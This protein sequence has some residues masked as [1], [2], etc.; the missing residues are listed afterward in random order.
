MYQEVEVV[1]QIA[2]G[3]LETGK[4]LIR[5]VIYK[6]QELLDRVQDFNAPYLEGT[7]HPSQQQNCVTI[8]H[9]YRVEIFYAVID[10]QLMKLNTIFNEKTRELLVLSS[11]LN[12]R[13]DFQ[14]FDIDNLCSLA[15]KYYPHDV[16]D[17]DDLRTKLEHFEYQLSELEEFQNL[18]TL[19]VLCQEFVRTRTPFVLIE[20]LVRLVMTLPVSTATIERAFSAMKIIKN[21]LRSKM[22]YGFLADLM[23]V[24]IEKD[25]VDTNDSDT[26]INEFYGLVLLVVKTGVS[27]LNLVLDG[28]TLDVDGARA[29]LNGEIGVERLSRSV[30]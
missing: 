22:S 17:L 25:I 13:F 30:W 10:F 27:G 18:C 6:E 26:V 2:A 8:E 3:E 5:H 23:T 15:E 11:S 9:Y 19:S 21:Q 7:G 28:S 29:N 1:E 4:E 24:H 16:L 12:P 20:R 14:S